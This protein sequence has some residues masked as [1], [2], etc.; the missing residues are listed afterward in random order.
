[1]SAG[2]CKH[3]ASGCDYPAS[4]CGGGCM[5]APAQP[6]DAERHARATTGGKLTADLLRELQLAHEIVRNALSLMT[7]A[8]RTDWALL[9][10]ASGNDSEGTTRFHERAAVIA[11]AMGAQS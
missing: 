1:M 11:R 10:V 9:N 2:T 8:Q 3:A 6:T 5:A 4:E 7:P